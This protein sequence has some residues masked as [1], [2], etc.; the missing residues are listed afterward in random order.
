VFDKLKR[1]CEVETDLWQSLFSKYF[2]EKFIEDWKDF[3]KN[4]NH[5]AHNKLLDLN[6]HKVITKS[7]EVVDNT[8]AIAE[9][10]FNESSLSDEE[11]EILLEIEEERRVE[12][13]MLEFERMESEAGITILDTSQIFDIFDEYVTNFIEGIKDSIYF[14]NDLET[15]TSDFTEGDKQELLSTY[16]K[17]TENKLNIKT[18]LFLNEESGEEST[19]TLELYINDELIETSDMTYTNGGAE[20]DDENGYYLPTAYNEFNDG[21]ID[22]FASTISIKIEECLP[23]LVEEVDMAKSNF[24]MDGGLYPVAESNCDECG[25]QY[26][27]IDESICEIGTCVNCGYMNQLEECERCENLYN[28]SS[29]GNDTFCQE[30]VTYFEDHY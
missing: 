12:I 14:R 5:V 20:Y 27:C 10:K 29:E 11:R 24:A 22:E 4:R 8:L 1:E 9:K 23:N 16:S 3:C 7:I 30:C 19:V 15:E 28:P 13:E 25:E 2:P 21:N 6:A 18:A 17:I 26:I